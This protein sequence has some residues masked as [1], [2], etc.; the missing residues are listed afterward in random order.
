M[1]EFHRLAP[2]QVLGALGPPSKHADG[3]KVSP[4]ERVLSAEWLDTARDTGARIIVWNDQI[5]GEA[6]ALAHQRGRKVWVYTIDDSEAASRLFD[7]GVDGLIS[8]NP[9]I[10]WKSLAT[11]RR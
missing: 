11:R 3:R 8:N 4:E 10:V 5:T 6:V 7:L 9:A 1:R 2:D